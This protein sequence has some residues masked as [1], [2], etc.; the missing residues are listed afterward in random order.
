MRA[1]WALPVKRR[2]GSVTAVIRGRAMSVSE[3]H[4]RRMRTRILRVARRLYALAGYGSVSMREIARS[5]GFT[6]QA[7]Y[8]YFPSK[9]AMFA[10]LAEEGLRLLELQHPSEEL[11]DTL[12]NLRLPFAR[13]YEFSKVHA[14]YFMLLFMD[15]AAAHAQQEPQRAL[16]RRM[17]D[18]SEQ[19]IQRCIDEGVFPADIDV[20]AAAR[21][22]I[23]GVHGPA[24]I[25]IT[26]RPWEHDLDHTAADVL[27]SMIAGLRLGKV[28]RR[29]APAE[30]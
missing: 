9:E 15:P 6:A 12:D 1:C 27:E 21:M 3:R 30:P 11:P 17:G 13:Y 28:A 10:A 25:G 23:G 22:L 18:D 14:E 16:I 5:L 7:I 26:G 19:R 2:S 4:Q 20:E 8:N 24:V 29:R